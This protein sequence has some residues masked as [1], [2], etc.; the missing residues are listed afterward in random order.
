ML[1]GHRRAIAQ[2]LNEGQCDEQ[3]AQ[4]QQVVPPQT[5]K[6]IGDTLSAKG[7][8]WAWYAGGWDAA[9]KA[10]KEKQRVRG[11]NFVQWWLNKRT[12]HHAGPH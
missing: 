8:S 4:G 11:Q 10:H 7:I 2:Q 1:R 9:V 3:R 12:P 5:Q 6:T